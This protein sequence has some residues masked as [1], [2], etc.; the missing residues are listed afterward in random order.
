MSDLLVD[1][2]EAPAWADTL[3]DGILAFNLAVIQE[4]VKCDIDGIMFG[5][6]WGQQRGL[7]F[8]P[9]LW[10]RFIKPRIAEMYAATRKAGKAVLIHC[11]GKVQELFPELIDVGLDVF[12]PFQPDVMDPYERA[13][14]VTARYARAS[15]R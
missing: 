8:G 5:D 11:C 2:L 7:L 3:L 12:N 13:A 4:M 10:R 1:M 14:V 15:A 9:R 6:D